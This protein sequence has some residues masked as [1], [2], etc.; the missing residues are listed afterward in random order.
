MGTFSQIKDELKYEILGIALVALGILGL[1]CLL[2]P[3]AGL[4]SSFI[5]KVLKSVAGEG[6]YILPFLLILVGAKF[7]RNRAQANLSERMYGVLVLFLIALT[8]FHLVIPV[9]NAF[10]AGFAGDGGGLIGA[11]VSYVA[12]KSFGI[13]GTYVILVAFSLIALLLLTKLSTA[14]MVKGFTTKV[15]NTFK[16]AVAR[17]MNFLF[18]EVEEEKARRT[19]AADHH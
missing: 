16:N 15:R 3:E 10:S 19:G 9:E 5:D 4:L 11:L 8:L 6:R 14:A 12:I 13:I 2:L 18:E 7:V 17:I 1:V